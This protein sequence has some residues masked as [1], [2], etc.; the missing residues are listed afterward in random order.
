MATPNPNRKTL[1][2]QVSLL[3]WERLRHRVP[4]YGDRSEVLRQLVEKFLAGD[5]VII[6]APR[7][8]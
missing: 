2:F 4:R 6:K 7:R 5:V 8:I 3:L 1:S